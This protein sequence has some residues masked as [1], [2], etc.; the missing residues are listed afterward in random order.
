MFECKAYSVVRFDSNPQVV[1]RKPVIWLLD[2]S[3]VV[4][5]FSIPSTRG[6]VP[7][8]L[9]SHNQHHKQCRNCT[10][11][12]TGS[13]AQSFAHWP[14]HILK[15]IYH[16]TVR[17]VSRLPVLPCRM[18][19]YVCRTLSTLQRQCLIS[20]QHLLSY[21]RHK[22]LYTLHYDFQH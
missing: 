9:H 11:L 5:L 4:K 17:S 18:H 12:H 14:T 20:A 3:R 19:S 13:T 16:V 7:V 1:G 15:L 21:C 8:I 2:R 22:R 6:R 10:C